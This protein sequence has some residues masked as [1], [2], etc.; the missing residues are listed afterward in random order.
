V[1]QFQSIGTLLSAITGLLV[2]VLVST[3]AMSAI[4]AF[5]RERQ[6]ARILA[7][8]TNA[9]SQLAAEESL[10]AEL[11]IAN[12]A[13]QTPEAADAALLN[14]VRIAHDNSEDK[15]KIVLDQLAD[16]ASDMQFAEG[17]RLG[18]LRERYRMSYFDVTAAIRMPVAQRPADL[19]P[20]WKVTIALLLHTI[21]NETKLLSNK[22]NGTDPFI[23]DMIKIDDSGW[24][25]RTDAGDDRALM[26]AA[27]NAT[28]AISAQHYE[29]LA[30]QKGRAD[31][32]WAD[33]KSYAERPATPQALKDA[34]ARTR[35]VY[36]DDYRAL[37]RD[38]LKKLQSGVRQPM[39]IKTF[40][41]VSNP[42]L[43]IILGIPHAALTLASAHA[44]EQEADAKR[45]FYFAIAM[46]LLSIGLATFTAFYAI[47]R[48]INP[49]NRITHTMTSIAGGDL[50]EKIP[51]ESRADEIGQFAHALQMF[52]DS[53]VE[54]ERLQAELLE[55]K[56]AKETAEVSNQIKS[57]FLANMSHE[58]RT[59]MNGILGMTSLLLDTSLND[60]Q[61]RFAKVV[62]ESGEGLMSILNDILDVSKLEA[63][64]LEIEIVDFDLVATV[65]SAAALMTSK[66][67]EKNID[68]AMFVDPQARGVYRGD[69][70]R[71]RQIL[72]NLLSNGIKF[73][74]KGGVALQVT[75]KLGTTLT[76]DGA[77]PLHFEVT[78]TGIG[79]AESVRTRMFQ[80]F[81]Q[82]DSSVTR[83][84]GGTGLGLAICKQLVECMGGEIGV[85]S[86]PGVGST[87]WFTIPLER[88]TITL[89]DRETVTGH[90]KNLRALVVDDIPLNLEIM[91]RQLHAL[92]VSAV[93]V[94]DGFAAMAELE[95]AWHRS[96]PYDI[97]FLDQMMPGL[98]GDEL[99]GRIRAHADL[100]E[101]RLI[102]VSSVGR[103]FIREARNL[104][105]EA[106]LE[107][108]VRHQEL[109]DTLANIYGV[110]GDLPAKNTETFVEAEATAPALQK[111]S[112]RILLAEDNKI[113]QQ[114]ATVLLTKA[115]HQVTIA[116]NGHQAVDAMRD[117]DF[118]V[119][120][121]DVQ[122]PELDGVQATRQI[123]MLPGLR[124]A[125]PIIAMT[126]HAMSGASEE[127]L[128]AGMNDYISKPFQPSLLLEKLERLALAI[129]SPDLSTGVSPAGAPHPEKRDAPAIL[130]SQNLED[131]SDSL[132]LKTVGGLVSLYC[133]SIEGHLQ[134][135]AACARSRDCGGIARQAHM[136]VGAAGNLGAMQTCLLAREIER[137]CASGDCDA[138]APMLTRLEESC[139]ASSAALRG[140]MD[141]KTAAAGLADAV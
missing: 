27:V 59:P 78:D 110:P 131:L 53:A 106:V 102:I 88:S 35:Q 64:K 61:R 69:P 9:Q 120:L 83:R 136:L 70:T 98:S 115:G 65:E 75:V 29:K 16:H 97:V 49:L 15:L 18:D 81:S 28:T 124:G 1:K 80:K 17:A 94:G 23:D 44:I 10:R 121:M 128:S 100:S 51:Y 119:V 19:F 114:Y 2:V 42:S 4:G 109:L 96:Q 71:V 135:I 90:F 68:L 104:K 101:T 41:D 125:V 50:H 21:D 117:N 87:F 60:E 84:F 45:H 95:R 6:A 139:A 72:L 25:L 26:V 133:N 76:T 63:G 137:A 74:E 86:R 40:M 105:L 3:F 56:S 123:R 107:K 54:R 5:D 12:L 111:S 58:I 67:R 93:T 79:M 113:N 7:S 62:Q 22:I 46:M 73:T 39:P 14:Q 36:F 126:A 138:L 130:D 85:S 140:W 57:E 132:D 118:D 34:I 52:R 8:V 108:P 103:D 55:N 89:A 24:K 38:I 116:E 47:A 129:V 66:A 82:A 77:V 13:L 32:R 99:A 31:A 20:K 141:S 122:M 91:R 112:L 48:V 43:K 92:G 134:E 11:T 127:Y 30:E 33:L 37:R